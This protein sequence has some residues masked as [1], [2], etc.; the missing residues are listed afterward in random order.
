MYTIKINF[1][2]KGLSPVTLE[3]QEAGQTLLEIA[4][5]NDIELH[6]NCGGVCACTTC[7][8]YIDRGME[9]VDEISDRE[10][11]FI[12]RAVNPRLTSRLGCQSL[13]LDGKGV[14]E[15]LLPDQTQFLGE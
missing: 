9:Y 3:K 6:H 1:E 7:H 5:K 12:D 13:L 8:L 4:L 11:D 2:E 14:I 10:E 15:I